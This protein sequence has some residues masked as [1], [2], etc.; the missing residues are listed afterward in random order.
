MVWGVWYCFVGGRKVLRLQLYTGVECALK[1]LRLGVSY[2]MAQRSLS[3][4]ELHFQLHVHQHDKLTS[5][6]QSITTYSL[7]NSTL[8]S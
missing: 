3:G 2:M 8:L 5:L 6:L 1:R 7:E 4:F